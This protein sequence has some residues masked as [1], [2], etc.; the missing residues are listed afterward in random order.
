MLIKYIKK[1]SLILPASIS[2]FFLIL[3]IIRCIYFLYLPDDIFITWTPDDSFYYQKLSCNFIDGNGWT[4]DEIT[5]TSGF[6][7]IH[8]YILVI[9]N[10]IFGC[11]SWRLAHFLIGII[12]SFSLAISCFLTI[13]LV[14]NYFGKTPS[15]L[16]SIPYISPLV[17]V[18]L[19]SLM[20]SWAVILTSSL[21]FYSLLNPLVI[22]NKYKKNKED[23]FLNFNFNKNK[24]LFFILGLFYIFS[25]NDG[26]VSLFILL[27]I[28]SSVIVAISY[29]KKFL[30]TKYI[31][32]FW[33]SF[34]T[35]CG[36]IAGLLFIFLH[37]II[38]TGSFL[39]SS[40]A[41]KFFWSSVAGHN[42]APFLMTIERVFGTFSNNSVWTLLIPWKFFGLISFLV[43]CYIL[44][45]R[46]KNILNHK[47]NGQDK[48][49][50]S[51]SSAGVIFGYTFFY[52]FNQS[53]IGLWYVFQ[54]LTP[55]SIIFGSFIEFIFPKN[56]S[57][58][59]LIFIL[60]TL[61][62][63]LAI[64][65]TL[66]V[67]DGP[68]LHQS[69]MLKAG[70]RLSKIE[71]DFPIASWNAGIIS[72]FSK[73]NVINIDG[74]VNN[75]ILKHLKNGTLLEYLNIKNVKYIADYDLMFL[76]NRLAEQGG[77]SDGK[78][79]KCVSKIEKL[80]GDNPGW[81]NS[82]LYLFKIKDNCK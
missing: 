47:L 59:P 62:S 8:A 26:I 25:R 48:F 38:F 65:S 39:Q 33:N 30:N 81:N 11:D 52:S 23:N 17:V 56:N 80:D 45:K 14:K 43:T 58:F 3:Y 46:L 44:Y 2:L 12:A 54:I 50:I 15:I 19:T 82:P 78:L 9:I 16:S 7:L 21:V 77:Y 71:L 24:Y 61:I 57:K 42:P 4:F 76:S 75:E 5:K 31:N 32:F 55:L 72:Y 29:R 64:R 6:H 10:Y 36:G 60:L 51:L 66:I 67:K 73:K 37:N 70:L 34:F 53:A 68:S 22:E 13:S 40:S 27:F 79:K 20:E 69:G 41:T 28:S 18:N 1:N 49:L 74:L 63:V 35:F